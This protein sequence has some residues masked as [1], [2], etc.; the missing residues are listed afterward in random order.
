MQSWIIGTSLECDIVVNESAVSAQHCQLTHTE[1]GL[2]FLEDLG[3]TNGT[4]LNGERINQRV[5][6]AAGE[7]VTLGN[8]VL[9]PWP[10]IA[11]ESARP[12]GV[13]EQALICGRDAD[14]DQVLDHPMISRRH[15]RLVPTTEGLQVEDLGSTNGTY[16]NGRRILE[17]ALAQKGDVIE[18]GTYAFTLS[19]D[20]QIERKDA[21][22]QMQLEARNI[23][24]DVPSQRLLENI[25]LTI[26]PGEFVGMMG[27]SG[28]GKSTLMNVLNGYTPPSEGS[29]LINGQDLYTKY[30]LFGGQLGYVP[31]DDIIHT[32][33]TV[34]QALYY[35]A[36]LRLPP[37]FRDWEIEQRIATVI[38]QLG[39]QG[40]ENVLIGSPRKKGIS[41]GQRKRV[42]LAMELLTDPSILF[43]D[44]PTS[45]LSSE[46]ALMV[47][48]LLSRMSQAGKTILLTIHQPSPEI[49]RLLDHLV[50]LSKDSTRSEPGQLVY[51]GPAYPDAIEFFDPAG[52]SQ[53]AGQQLSADHVLRGLSRQST[54]QWVE[55]YAQSEHYR[56]FVLQR[57]SQTPAPQA[58]AA[59]VSRHQIASFDQGATLVRRGVTIKL[60]DTWNTILLLAQ[61]PIIGLLI[62]M[63]FG[64]KTRTMVHSGNWLEVAT[65]TSKAIFLTALSALWFGCSNS[66]REIVGEWAIYRRE[67]MVNLKIPA[68]LGSKFTVLGGICLIQC[69]ILLGIV[70]AGTGLQSNWFAM[71]SVLL[72]TSLVGVGIGLLVST[73][74]RTSEV[75]IAC[76]PLVLLPMVILGGILQP[77]HEMNWTAKWS[78]QLMP[79]RWAFESLLVME[80]NERAAAPADVTLPRTAP[81][82][83]DS[84]LE[85]LTSGRILDDD[86]GL[87]LLAGSGATPDNDAEQEQADFA[88]L[89]FP[90]DAGRVGS[91]ASCLFLVVMLTLLTGCVA[92][93]LRRRDIH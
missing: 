77:R 79:S 36:R 22:G 62:A 23:S 10:V 74:A 83:L 9:M 75:A 34:Q 52:T 65:E 14:C 86:L 69:L 67:R 47:M 72:I 44:E 30:G 50:L 19:A 89:F 11:E 31:Q 71:F 29:V 20:G 91:L 56:R 8:N 25:S 51:F 76:L 93:I 55:Q 43:L 27:P 13:T 17:P 35:N 90:P 6:V 81:G 40:T 16:L 41:G 84:L 60:R 39:L 4:F 54:A 21:R 37:D 92:V 24:V 42:N 64:S 68:Y 53:A 2:Y 73:V 32:D 18:L 1:N 12:R 85:Q 66:A 49:Y 7:R 45:G 33:L 48:T 70:H 38:S 82:L 87:D 80:A 58:E 88:A 78:S 61:A 57:R 46:D 63:V 15:V 5:E 26:R 59:I 28:A 3:S